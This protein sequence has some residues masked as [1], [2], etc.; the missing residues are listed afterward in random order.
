MEEFG[1]AAIFL[2]CLEKGMCTYYIVRRI[3][4]R[5]IEGVVDVA[6]RCEMDNCTYGIFVKQM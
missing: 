5:V 6:L 2:G 4:E 1:E 3:L